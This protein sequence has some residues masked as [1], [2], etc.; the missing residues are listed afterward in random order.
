[1][2]I[3]TLLFICAAYAFSGAS[4]LPV[5]PLLQ[6]GL[7]GIAAVFLLRGIGFVALEWVRPGSLA[8]VSGN[9]GMDAFLVVSSLICLSIGAL[10]LMGILVRY[11]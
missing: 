6:T 10:Y 4:L 8:K 11:G 9:R 2:V 5:L 1:M 3:A 7:T